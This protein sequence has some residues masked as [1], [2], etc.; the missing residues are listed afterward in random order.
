MEQYCC[1]HCG[2]PYPTEKMYHYQHLP[3]DIDSARQGESGS[4]CVLCQ[5]ELAGWVSRK[6]LADCDGSHTVNP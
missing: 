4:L 2:E 3:F 1:D 5:R 6:D